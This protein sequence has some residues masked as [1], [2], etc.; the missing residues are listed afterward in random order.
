M[1]RPTRILAWVGGLFVLLLVI[2]L[3]APFL[4]RGRIEERAKLEA[5]KNLEAKVDWRD[6]GLSFF[7]NFPNLTVTL[8]DL[9]VTGKGKFNGD[10]LA[11]IRHFGVVLDLGSVH[12]QSHQRPPDRG[13][14][15]RSRPSAALAHRVSRT[16]RSTGTS[17]RRLRRRRP[18]PPR[19]RSSISLTRFKIGDAVVGFD[20]RKA[21]S[22]RSSRGSTRRSP[23]TSARRSSPSRPRPTPTP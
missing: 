9:A 18:R 21:G 23:A 6:L 7:G 13:P 4:F 14:R 15:H 20:D 12:R 22:R 8:N 11:A 1:T 2:L 10:T 3:T 16:V 19:S 17:P 5:N